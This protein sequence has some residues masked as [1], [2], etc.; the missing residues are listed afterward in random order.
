MKTTIF[1]VLVTLTFWS[2]TAINAQETE[3]PAEWQSK[4]ILKTDLGAHLRGNPAVSILLD[5]HTKSSK[6][7]SF[8]IDL[9]YGFAPINQ[10]FPTLPTATYA[11]PSGAISYGFNIK[12]AP[13]SNWY[14][15][16]SVH[17][18]AYSLAYEKYTCLESEEV[19]GLCKCTNW[20]I[21]QFTHTNMKLNISGILGY[22]KQ[23]KKLLI[24]LEL[25]LGGYRV[26]N[27]NELPNLEDQINC[28]GIGNGV[29]SNPLWQFAFFR[30]DTNYLDGSI[31]GGAFQFSFFTGYTF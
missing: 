12:H 28:E 18:G 27:L 11:G 15:G 5:Y 10:R 19:A 25:K 17:L 20:T 3:Q 21:D 1:S 16:G 4:L 26:W 29:R 2:S 13:H 9:V 8:G 7:H 30:N 14:S 23:I 31:T 24:G 22:Q 6:F